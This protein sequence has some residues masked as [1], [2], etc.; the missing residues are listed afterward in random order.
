MSVPADIQTIGVDWSGAASSATQRSAIWIAV[1][2]DGRLHALE[3]GRTRAE[4][5]DR[6]AA[7]AAERPSVIGLDFSFSLPRWYM[8]EQGWT[9]ARELWAWADAK[10]RAEEAATPTG[11]D[12]APGWPATLPEP[13]WGPRI[14]RLPETLDPDRRF[15]RTEH[16]SARPGAIPQ[17][18]F[19]LTGAG[20]VGS[21]SLRGMVRLHRFA[22]A[23]VWPVD[24]P[25]WPLVVEVFPRLMLRELRPDLT[26][27][28]G[29]ALVELLVETADSGLWGGRDEW[30]E[31]L[32]E[33]QDALDAAIS[34][35]GLWVSRRALAEL[36]PETEHTYRLEGRIWSISLAE[37]LAGAGALD[38]DAPAVRAR[39]HRTIP[40]GAAVESALTGDPALAP[41]DT[42]LLLEIYRLMR[43][44]PPAGLPRAQPAQEPGEPPVIELRDGPRTFVA[45]WVAE[46][47]VLC[48]LPF[49]TRHV[50]ALH[51]HGVRTV[52][53]MCEDTEYRGDQRADVTA[54]YAGREMVEH[55][56]ATPDGSAPPPATV[57]A[58]VDLYFGARRRGAVAV[59][60]L[61]GRERSATIAAAIR[62]RL[63]GEPGADAIAAIERICPDV[64]LLPD[65]MQ[66]L[67]RWAADV[68]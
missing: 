15:R 20:S 17:S 32:A 1:V 39:A 21:Q 46:G 5:F 31:S 50:A 13:F 51:E 19:Q 44:R 29:A 16:A 14:R 38:T 42:G 66:L 34:A 64:C 53:N 23:H 22:G 8:E 47:L 25:G 60:C 63:L 35:W 24:D 6:L 7:L 59:H 62:S 11:G 37:R 55:R 10:E 26:E 36:Q 67:V 27:L 2:R 45:H 68:T 54:A 48:N 52:L 41:R 4:A 56:L 43:D 61:G 9:S 58:A 49:A 57:A 40:G 18:P 12:P 33:S 65:Q 30:R 28:S 3:T